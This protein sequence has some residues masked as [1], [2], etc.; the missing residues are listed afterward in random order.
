MIKYSKH[1]SR[2]RFSEEFRTQRVREYERG[3]ITISEICRLYKVSSTSVYKWLKKYSY[4]YQNNL[5]VVEEQDSMTKKLKAAEERIAELERTLGQKQIKVDYLETL[6]N[7]AGE[8]FGTD[9]KKTLSTKPLKNS[10]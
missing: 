2:R 9:L 5:V 7:V 3:E 6:V 4:F 8:Y 1:G 10:D